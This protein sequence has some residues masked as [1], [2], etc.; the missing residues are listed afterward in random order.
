MRAGFWFLSAMLFFVFLEDSHSDLFVWDIEYIPPTP[1]IGEET[2]SCS[3]EIEWETEREKR[4]R[5]DGEGG[6]GRLKGRNVSWR[7]RE[8]EIKVYKRK[9]AV[10]ERVK[11]ENWGRGWIECMISCKN[12][13]KSVK[14]LLYHKVLN[15]LISP[16]A[17]HLSHFLWGI[18]P[19]HFKSFP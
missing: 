11:G 16:A 7:G 10:R 6:A 19:D 2:I 13:R 18:I 17:K 15:V 3:R 5:E 9:D 14:K 12:T 1:W 8:L 4:G